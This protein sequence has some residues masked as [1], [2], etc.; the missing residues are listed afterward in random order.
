[1]QYRISF[2]IL[3]YN[4]M[5]QTMECVNSIREKTG[6]NFAGIVIVDNCSPDGSG[7]IL[8]E[9]FR[10]DPKIRVILLNENLGFAGG[11]NEGYKIAKEEFSSDFVC[12]LNNDVI[13]QQNDFVEKIFAEYENSLCAVIGPHITLKNGASNYMTFC[14]AEKS[15]YERQLKSME[16][17]YSHLKSIWFPLRNFLSRI[18]NRVLIF[19][20]IRKPQISAEQKND[21]SRIRHE[22]IILHGCCLIFTP[23][24]LKKFSDAFNPKTFMFREEELLF[25]R[26]KNVGLKNVYNP[27][28]DVLHLEDVST[29]ATYRRK[30][31]RD[32][33]MCRCQIDSLKI[34]ISELQN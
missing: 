15:E 18:K 26:L 12:I 24:Y 14:L 13:L 28:L 3:H 6:G 19:L 22:N 20:R 8:H 25:L 21:L 30:R 1:M 31:A 9:K 32:L 2:V 16:I 4:V 34:L 5:A 11:N 10:S 33:F 29:N 27:Q 7:K 17:W 23:V